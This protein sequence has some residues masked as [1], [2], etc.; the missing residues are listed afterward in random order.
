[1]HWGDDMTK[2]L[3]L[4]ASKTIKQSNRLVVARYRL[5]KYEQRMMIAICS[6]LNKDADEF[7]TIRVNV[8]DLADFCHFKGEDAYRKVHSTMI[9]LMSRTL[10]IQMEN[11]KWYITHWLQ[12]AKYLN[13]GIIE[14]C[15]DQNLKPE[16]LQ[17]KSAYL[18]TSVEPLMRFK[19][20]YSARLYFILRKIVKLKDYTYDLDFFIDRFQLGK[21]YK[22][23]SNLKNRVIEPAL[24]EINEKSD[25]SVWHEYIKEGRSYKKIHFIVDV[26]SEKKE[27][28]NPAPADA[29][30]LPQL[31]SS[32]V[33]TAET[34]ET[35]D[36][37]AG[38]ALLKS[39]GINPPSASVTADFKKKEESALAPAEEKNKIA[40]ADGGEDSKLT[41]EQQADYD[42]L[43][44]YEIWA[45]TAKKFVIAYDH[46]R[47]ERN[48]KGCTKSKS[49]GNIRDFG[50]VL[51]D[52]I[53]NDTYQGEGEAEEQ[54]KA[55]EREKARE[56][57][58]AI[59]KAKTEEMAKIREQYTPDKLNAIMA[60][61]KNK[62]DKSGVMTEEMQYKL[63]KYGITVLQFYLFRTQNYIIGDKIEKAVK[64]E[65]IKIDFEIDLDDEKSVEKIIKAYYKNG[66]K[67]P[68]K[69]LQKLNQI[70]YNWNDFASKNIG[71]ILA[72][73]KIM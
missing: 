6:Q 7:E 28:N 9:K 27:I 43:I 44:K 38:T 62:Y 33:V 40:S 24:E 13:G 70:G 39:L 17:L 11:G 72:I 57:Q 10:Q 14:Y 49:K 55:I 73:G 50:A 41:A 25:I 16:L 35:T 34:A 61:V 36:H 48:I 21:T 8:K 69:I 15:I 12:T 67:C 30:Q 19:R 23:I 3:K 46:E 37:S 53:A 18:T 51:A 71:K 22:Q 65:D 63:N 60:E 47:I 26:K 29:E 56:E 64:K 58:K 52:A 2:L 31:T 20:D 59:N 45:K 1:M 32:P 68:D 54:T 4:D 66:K 5:T 42:R